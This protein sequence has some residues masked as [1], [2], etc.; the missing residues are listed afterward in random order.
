MAKEGLFNILA[1][2]VDF[3]ELSVLDLFAGT[4]N[5]AFEFASRGTPEILC[6]DQNSKC[7][8]FINEFAGKLGLISIKTIRADVLRFLA[9]YRK[10]NNFIFA[11]PPYDFPNY[12]A[13]A[14]LVFNN[15]ILDEGGILVIEHPKDVSF[16]EHPGFKEVRR[17]GHVHFSF[18]NK[19]PA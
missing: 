5:I 2:Q 18:F 13:I 7:L 8:S 17:Y 16:S 12:Q 1:N 11:D 10:K 15:D 3:E 14:E 9:R 6:I 4:G 19:L